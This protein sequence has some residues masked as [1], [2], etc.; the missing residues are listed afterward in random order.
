MY[1][2]VVYF[3][4]DTRLRVF[5]DAKE[6]ISLSLY[7]YYTCNNM[8]KIY[9]NASPHWNDFAKFILTRSEASSGKINE[10]ESRKRV[11]F[12]AII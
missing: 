7:I 1:N 3:L 11:D 2:F 10:I 4:E 9:I 12:L 8:R 6:D 5:L